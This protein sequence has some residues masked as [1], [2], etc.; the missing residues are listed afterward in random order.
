MTGAGEI[1]AEIKKLNYD[2][3]IIMVGNHP[4]ALP[5]R[6]LLE[7]KVDYVCDGEGPRTIMGLLE[8]LPH[9]RTPGLVWWDEN[10]KITQNPTAPLIPI[11]ELHGDVWSSLPM[12]SYRAHSWQCFGDLSRRAPYASIY[13]TLGC[14]FACSFC[15]INTFQHSNT[16]RMRN[17]E[18]VVDEL[19]Y[20]HEEFGIST[21]KFADEMFV[22]AP[23]HYTA[24][25]DG[26]IR[27][28]LGDKLNI[29][30]Y[31]RIDTVKPETLKL[32]RAA[33]IQWL[34]LG[35]ESGS[36]FVRDGAN[37]HLRKDD[38]V[39]VV[40]TIQNAGINVI[41]N[42]MFGLRDDDIRTMDETYRL[43]IE[44]MPDF[45]NFYS[46]MA[47]P[48]SALYAQAIKEGWTLPDSWRGFSQHNDDCRP[49]DTEHIPG[50]KVLAYRDA[51]FTTFFRSLE[52]TEHVERKFGAETLAH[53]RKMTTY[54]LKR[55]LL[56][57]AA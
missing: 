11:D 56:E 21:V 47:Y 10:G 4:S 41:G 9:H 51:A 44:C 27:R 48:G 36:K 13:T 32:L 2:R 8:E 7:E 23:K 33:G 34:A 17:P 31:S 24:I 42:F 3:K 28:N 19:E 57:S 43:A 15:M 46:C 5:V 39:E 49:L 20:L 38:I 55:K 30:A 35:I 6:T 25:C 1:A 29:W 26:L 22:M 54:K 40:R 16:Y 37:K 45:A 14:P 18:L 53:V 50:G 52:Y 12:Q